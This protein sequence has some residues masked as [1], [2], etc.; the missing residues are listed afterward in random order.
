MCQALSLPNM[1]RQAEELVMEARLELIAREHKSMG[2]VV[3]TRTL[4]HLEEIKFQTKQ[5]LRL[6]MAQSLHGRRGGRAGTDIKSKAN[7]AVEAF[8]E[9]GINVAIL[10]GNYELEQ[11]I[12]RNKS[13][14]RTYAQRRHLQHPELDEFL[15]SMSSNQVIEYQNRIS[16]KLIEIVEKFRK[17]CAELKLEMD[18]NGI[19][20]PDANAQRVHCIYLMKLEKGISAANI[21]DPVLKEMYIEEYDHQCQQLDLQ[22]KKQLMLKDLED[23]EI[24]STKRMVDSKTVAPSPEKGNAE[25]AKGEN[26]LSMMDTAE[27]CDKQVVDLEVLRSKIVKLKPFQ[28]KSEL[29]VEENT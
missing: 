20:H 9:K 4:H 27:K 25:G 22:I 26:I 29:V 5:S 18:L 14:K 19:F 11:K 21:E 1:L 17:E 3:D 2:A 10:T 15:N 24:Q 6:E 16:Q 23:K 12:W 28:E 8:K 7:L 13:S